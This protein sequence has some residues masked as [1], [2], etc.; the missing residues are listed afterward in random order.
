MKL[1]PY[2]LILIAFFITLSVFAQAVFSPQKYKADIDKRV[3]NSHDKVQY[4][5]KL[6]GTE[7][8]I[9]I[10]K[11]NYWPCDV[12]FN[13]SLFYDAKGKLIYAVKE[14]EPEQGGG[15]TLLFAFYFLPEGQTVASHKYA[16]FFH[17]FCA[18]NDVIKEVD[19]KYYD[20]NFKQLDR[21]YSLVTDT[22]HKL[23]STQCEHPHYF[24]YNF[25]PTRDAFLK[26]SGFVK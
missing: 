11:P 23:D 9:K 8:P 25:P 3:N 7:K 20:K 15:W 6:K 18:G 5:V 17:S 22:G 19:I 4:F 12:E 16:T 21:N 14:V 24:P 1:K 10:P 26:E 2:L 13:Y